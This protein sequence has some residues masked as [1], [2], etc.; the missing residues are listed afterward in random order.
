VKKIDHK[1]LNKNKKKLAKR[2]KRKNYSRIA[3]QTQS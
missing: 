3:T 1:I 2:L